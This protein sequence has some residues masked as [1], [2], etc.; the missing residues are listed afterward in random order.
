MLIYFTTAMLLGTIPRDDL[1][2]LYTSIRHK[3]QR[4]PSE[5]VPD[6]ERSNRVPI[7]EI[8]L[9]AAAERTSARTRPLAKTS[10]PLVDL[11]HEMQ[12]LNALPPI[13]DNEDTL[14]MK[15]MRRLTIPETPQVSF[16]ML[17]H[18]QAHTDA[19][20]SAPAD[21]EIFEDD[22]E[23]LRLKTIRKPAIPETPQYVSFPI[24]Q[25]EQVEIDR[26]R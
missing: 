20:Q 7:A 6:E 21:E 18:E 17:E 24:L 16:S 4:T 14:P 11:R 25:K 9:D 19:P 1:K 12:T 26:G 8:A 13:E 3:T 15:A 22:E 2:A 5:V 23:T 10:S